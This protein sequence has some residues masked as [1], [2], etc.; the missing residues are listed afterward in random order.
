MQQRPGFTLIELLV[1]IGIIAVLAAMSLP[2]ISMI[3]KQAKDALCRNNLQQIGI[4]ITGFQQVN[5]NRFPATFASLFASGGV[6]AS[7]SPK[8][9][10]CPFDAQKGSSSEMGRPLSW[11]LLPELYQPS[12]SY[13]FE[14]AD[15]NMNTNVKSWLFDDGSQW[16][17]N[18]RITWADA[19]VYALKHDNT[20][21]RP[22]RLSDFP[23]VRCFWHAK[24]PASYSA[25]AEKRV[26]NLA[27]DMSLFWSIPKW[28]DQM[29]GN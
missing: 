12:C 24:W 15:V 14:A 13:I 8:L 29:R 4:G 19:K 21:N 16:G 9:L 25:S 17:D 11:G 26:L 5:N 10:L 7:E 23:I 18:G 28:E 20:G 3:R 2:I 22:F 1:V 27:W 6:M